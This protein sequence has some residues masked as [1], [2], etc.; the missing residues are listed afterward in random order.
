MVLPAFVRRESA[1][2]VGT[3]EFYM[4]ACML[5]CIVWDR[6]PYMCASRRHAG[7][8]LC[9]SALKNSRLI[10]GGTERASIVVGFACGGIHVVEVNE[11]M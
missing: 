11:H 6:P 8:S 1:H 9:L 3:H 2:P 5:I 4:D 10:D 7:I